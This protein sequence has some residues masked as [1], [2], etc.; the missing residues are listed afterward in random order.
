LVFGALAFRATMDAQTPRAATRPATR[1]Q[2]ISQPKSAS[3]PKTAWGDPDLQGT[4]NYATMTPVER[5]AAFA[6]KDVLTEQEAAAYEAQ[7]I[8]RQSTTN[9]T[10]GPDWWDPGQRHLVNRR[11]SLI[12]DPL[13]GRIPPLTPEAQARNAEQQRARRGRGQADDPEQMALN[14]RCLGWASAGPP[15]LPAVYNNNVQI[16]QTKQYVVIHNEMIHDARIIPIDGRPHGTMPRW[17]GDSRGHWEGDTLVVDTVNFNS[18]Q[19]FRG[20]STHLHLVERLTRTGADGLDYKVTVEDP[21]VWTA[22]WTIDLPMR[23]TDDLMYEYAC[24][25]GNER[26]M[27]GILKSARYEEAHPNDK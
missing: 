3:Q 7:T 11:T 16:V 1:A 27:V 9:N 22:P 8:A 13:N 26:S 20:S 17:M 15:M 6:G 24:H 12:V 18:E 5:P 4:Y 25:E 21:T 23:R 10:A 19:S 14:V 2:I